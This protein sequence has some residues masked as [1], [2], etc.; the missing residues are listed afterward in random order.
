MM[1]SKQKL[2]VGA[3]VSLMA[4]LALLGF[5]GEAKADEVPPPKPN[6]ETN[7]QDVL[8]EILSDDP[9]TA[10]FYQIKQGDNLSTIV[11]NAL[12]R[13]VPGA[14]DDDQT[15]I[16]YMKC[17]SSSDWNRE[18]YGVSGDHTENFPRYTSPDDVY[19]RSS[20]YPKHDNAISAILNRNVPNRGGLVRSGNSYS[21]GG[22]SS[23]G[24]L[25]LPAVNNATLAEFQE[26]QC[27]EQKWPDGESAMEPPVMLFKLFGD[28]E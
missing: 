24:M 6:D 27:G 9:T 12:N 4:I 15:R 23:Y 14:G 18:L 20:F 7:P 22:G 3:G 21:G 2:Y 16:R 13:A 26:P 5:A 8:D 19:I 11:R 10:K 17:I 25:W 1:S 28:T